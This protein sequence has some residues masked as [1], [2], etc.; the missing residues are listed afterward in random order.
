M[1]AEVHKLNQ[2]IDIVKYCRDAAEDDFCQLRQ[3][4]GRLAKV[5]TVH[6]LSY[7]V[8]LPKSSLQTH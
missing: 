5:R 6:S 8:L 7:P 3:R 4:S 1:E 2:Y